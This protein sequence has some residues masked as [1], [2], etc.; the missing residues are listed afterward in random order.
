[1]APLVLALL[2][3]GTSSTYGQAEKESGVK[4]AMRKKVAYSQQVLVGVT[5]EDYG[6]IVSN[7]EKLVEL[8]NKTNW[9]SRQAPEYELFLNEFRR[10][11]QELMKAG[12]QKNL[13]AASLAYVQ[14]TLSCVSCH[15][16]IRQSSGTGN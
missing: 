14:M 3:A 1:M 2:L 13:D 5:M 12:Q 11:A 8:S 7:A 10:N 4:E 6:L 15:Q 16:Y 9:Y